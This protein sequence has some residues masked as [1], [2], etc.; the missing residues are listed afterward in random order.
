MSDRAA[1]NERLRDDVIIGL[2]VGLATGIVLSLLGGVADLSL[3][4]HQQRLENLRFVRERSSPDVDTSRPFRGLDLQE[5][6]LSGLDL[7]E[8][9]MVSALLEEADLRFIHL[10]GAQLQRADLREANL[11]DSSLYGA[12][13]IGAQLQ[14]AHVVHSFAWNAEFEGADLSGTDFTRTALRA[15]DFRGAKNL[16]KARLQGSCWDR[17][18]KWPEGFEPP[19]S[20]DPS[21]CP[22]P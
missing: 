17:T 5:Q 10:Q 11:T 3:A 15:A 9:K 16:D 12:K 18:T 21:S 2:M 20:A 22:R 19:P 13:F 7:P 14:D 8:A 6:N 4:D 1:R